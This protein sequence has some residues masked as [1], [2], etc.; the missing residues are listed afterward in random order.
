MILIGSRASNHYYNCTVRDT[1]IVITEK[2]LNEVFGLSFEDSPLKNKAALKVD[3]VE[4]INQ[5]KTLNDADLPV[6]QFTLIPLKIAGKEVNVYLPTLEYLYAIRRSHVFRPLN[7]PKHIWHLTMIQSVL[8]ISSISE[9][10]RAF[11]KDRIKLTKAAYGDRVPKLNK[12]NMDFFDDPV[13]KIYEHDDLHE[14]VAFMD[15]PIYLKMKRD[16]EMAMCEKDMWEDLT[17][18][19]KIWCVQ[20]ESMVIALERFLIT[21]TINNPRIAFLKALEKVCTNLTSGW[22]RDFAIDN[23]VE[24]R[25]LNVDFWKIFQDNR[26]SLTLYGANH[27]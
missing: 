27:A 2:E 15:E 19:Q 22:F 24:C 26:D 4:F 7:F 1:D 18:Q 25:N 11:L 8:D 9:E 13:K 10:C 6:D 20:E 21:G 5:D 17:H 12:T 23:Y 14:I 16:K 3:G